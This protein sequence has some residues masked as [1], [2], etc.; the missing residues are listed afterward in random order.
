[1][2]RI[3][4]EGSFVPNEIINIR[5]KYDQK[6]KKNLNNSSIFKSNFSDRQI[7][8]FILN[9]NFDNNFIYYDNITLITSNLN[10][11]KV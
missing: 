7:N 5:N 1:M 4:A 8:D 3:L 2:L 6:K 10:I 11:L 9:N